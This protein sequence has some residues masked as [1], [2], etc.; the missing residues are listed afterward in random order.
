MKVFDFG[1]FQK[2]MHMV[3]R[4]KYIFYML[5]GVFHITPGKIQTY[6]IESSIDED[7]VARISDNLVISFPSLS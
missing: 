1:A 2:N 6:S 7:T 4:E 5:F 3:S